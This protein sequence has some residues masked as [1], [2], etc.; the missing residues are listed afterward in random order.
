MNIVMM[1]HKAIPSRDGGIEVVVEELSK[2]M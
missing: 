2:R 1:G